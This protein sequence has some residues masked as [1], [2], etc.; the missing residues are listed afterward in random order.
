MPLLEWNSFT[1]KIKDNLKNLLDSGDYSDVT[2]VTDDKTL[3]NVHKAVVSSS[4]RMLKEIIDNSPSNHPC[5]YL[6]GIKAEEINPVLQII[7]LGSTQ[8][9]MN[10]ASAVLD[11]AK[12]LQVF[13]IITTNGLDEKMVN[14]NEMDNANVQADAK[15]DSLK[16]SCDKCDYKARLKQSLVVHTRS[17]HE[18]IKFPCSLCDYK[19]TEKG[20]LKKHIDHIHEGVRY[21]CTECDYVATRLDSIKIHKL[22]I[23]NGYK[24]S[25]PKCDYKASRQRYVK[26]H[27]D[28]KHTIK[29]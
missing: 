9:P 19:A 7:Y 1:D 16:Y 28:E 20:S 24:F 13:D 8:I 17:I 14:E 29:M 3:F 6:K 27:M 21:P 2:L 4:S 22:T 10:Q 15:G 25:C 18:G 11:T 26:K 5:I 12:S 23:H